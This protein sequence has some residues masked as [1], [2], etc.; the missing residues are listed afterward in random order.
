MT[1]FDYSELDPPDVT[2]SRKIINPADRTKLAGYIGT[3]PQRG[4]VYVSPRNRER[5]L[6]RKH[7]G[8]AI[9]ED[10]LDTL[11]DAPVEVVFIKE[12]QEKMIEYDINQF[13]DGIQINHDG[14]DKQR[15]VPVENARKVWE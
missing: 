5:H 6:F 13:K 9:S 8:Y 2:K 15:V 10:I 11:A 12:D 4:M 3:C 7:Q 14:Y 1:L